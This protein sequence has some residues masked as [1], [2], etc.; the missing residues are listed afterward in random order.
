MDT[1]KQFLDDVAVRW[2]TSD[3][4]GKLKEKVIKWMVAHAL[5]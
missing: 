1:M 3:R 5:E 4:K 2:T